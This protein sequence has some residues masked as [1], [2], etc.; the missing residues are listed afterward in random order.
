MWFCPVQ[1]P[2]FEREA[3][4]LRPA[5]DARRQ[6]LAGCAA[7][8]LDARRT[9]LVR[10]LGRQGRLP[11]GHPLARRLDPRNLRLEEFKR[12]GLGETPRIGEPHGPRRPHRERDAPRTGGAGEGHLAQTGMDDGA[13]L[14]HRTVWLSEGYRVMAQSTATWSSLQTESRRKQALEKRIRMSSSS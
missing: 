9:L 3:R 6:V 10:Q 13:L 14:G 5:L 4:E 12:P 2:H 1:L 7:Q 11:A 8:L